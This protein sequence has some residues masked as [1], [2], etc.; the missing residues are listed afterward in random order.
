MN[1]NII[2][3]AEAARSQILGGPW[4]GEYDANFIL[5]FEV[6]AAW[7]RDRE[8]SEAEVEAE[9][10]K[11]KAEALREAALAILMDSFDAS[12]ADRLAN[13]GYTEYAEDE[14]GGLTWVSAPLSEVLLIVRTC[15]TEY[16]T[17]DQ[18]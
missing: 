17:G 9:V 12:V 10:C 5:G 4:N 15:V 1:E 16:E 13:A 7:E 14:D 8:P 11:A 2:E 6:G 3:A 18:T